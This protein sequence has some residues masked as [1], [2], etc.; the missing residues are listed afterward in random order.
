MLQKLYKYLI[1]IW[2]AYNK[3][4]LVGTYNQKYFWNYK[5]FYNVLP[6]LDILV[7]DLRC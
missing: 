6:N 2:T 3:L 7:N 4:N 1:H 5:L